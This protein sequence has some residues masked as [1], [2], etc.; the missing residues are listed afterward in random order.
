LEYLPPAI[1]L[2]AVTEKLEQPTS[3]GAAIWDPHGIR[4]Q[5]FLERKLLNESKY[6]IYVEYRV[7]VPIDDIDIQE[8]S[9]QN[10]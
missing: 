1:L 7:G 8:G 9:H 5:K 6:I 3:S 10:S 4:Q 2:E